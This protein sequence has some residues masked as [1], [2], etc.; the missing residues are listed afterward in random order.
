MD[1]LVQTVQTILPASICFL[2]PA[3]SI[4][5]DDVQGSD[6]IEYLLVIVSFEVSWLLLSC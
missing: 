3:Q 2:L 1:P 5:V 4:V 6:C